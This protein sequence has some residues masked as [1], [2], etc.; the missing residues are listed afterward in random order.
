MI[1]RDHDN[2]DTGHPALPN[3]IENLRPRRVDKR[4]ET[5]KPEAL[6]RKVGWLDRER[7]CPGEAIAE[8]EI[9]KTEDTFT[10]KRNRPNHLDQ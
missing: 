1:S 10:Y 7:I 5:E 3:G 8:H 9:T 2:L 6:L 4:Y